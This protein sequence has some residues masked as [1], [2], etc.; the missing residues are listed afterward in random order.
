MDGV[1]IWE[2]D[3]E[4]EGSGLVEGHMKVHL[5]DVLPNDLAFGNCSSGG[6]DGTMY[7]R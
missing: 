4:L 6:R 1:P 5:Y 3:K 7:H 2:T